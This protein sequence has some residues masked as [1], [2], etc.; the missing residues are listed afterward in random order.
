MPCVQFACP[1]YKPSAGE[2]HELDYCI[3]Q[4]ADR[5]M[6]AT[7]LVAIMAAERANHH[8]GAYLSATSLFGCGRS[9][10]LSRTLDYAED[11]RNLYYGYR[12]SVIH[13][14][15]E[16][17]TEAKVFKDG[18]N[19]LER[20]WLSE[21]RML[22]GFCVE[23]GGFQVPETVDPWNEETW[24]EAVCPHCTVQPLLLGGTMDQ[25]EPLWG[26]FDPE[27]GLLWV[28]IID[29]KSMADYAV[30]AFV[31][32]EGA[33]PEHRWQLSL[34]KYM[35]E[36]SRVPESLQEKGVRMIKVR[37]ATIQA[38]GMNHAPRTGSSYPFKKHY[39]HPETIWEVPAIEFPTDA[40]IESLV[41]ERGTP[42]ME[43]LILRQHTGRV[44]APEKNSYKMW[45]WRCRFCPMAN[46]IHCPNP[47]VEY[48]L[49]QQGVSPQESL[50]RARQE[51]GFETTLEAAPSLDAA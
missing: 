36:R 26:E 21:F 9:L 49:N 4:C 48:A 20:G 38:F 34:Y 16:Q 43:S 22:I 10:V 35:L 7:L 39:S 19:L 32:A 27:V 8:K 12:G 33:K 18:T 45:S 1:D 50:L 42:I 15:A 24:A 37:G 23:H 30:Q 46:S 40:E 5:C 31:T 25:A 2:Q 11:P 47:E 17:A 28:D 51:S 3:E 13:T 29:I 14:V 41:R 44:C 6:S